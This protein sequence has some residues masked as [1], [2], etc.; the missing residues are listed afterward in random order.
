MKKLLYHEA[1]GQATFAILLHVV[2][3]LLFNQHK[4]TLLRV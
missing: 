3:S 2:F 1:C 4:I